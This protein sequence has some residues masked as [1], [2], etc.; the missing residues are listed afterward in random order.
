MILVMKFKRRDYMNGKLK[1]GK[2][3]LMNLRNIVLNF[4]H[5]EINGIFIYICTI[6]KKNS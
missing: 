6:I 4:T 1:I 2:K 5:M 3:Y